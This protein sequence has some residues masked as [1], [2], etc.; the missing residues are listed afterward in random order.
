[1]R[2]TMRMVVTMAVRP[3]LRWRVRRARGD[4]ITGSARLHHP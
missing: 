1:M 2:V 3:R 4:G